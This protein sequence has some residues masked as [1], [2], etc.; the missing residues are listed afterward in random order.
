MNQL[1]LEGQA[2]L[3]ETVLPEGRMMG[4]GG[5]RRKLAFPLSFDIFISVSLFRGCLSWFG[6]S[7]PLYG[8]F[9]FLNKLVL[10]LSLTGESQLDS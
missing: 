2:D 5:S 6:V 8:G 4:G 3:K 7:V 1:Q 10:F 9:S